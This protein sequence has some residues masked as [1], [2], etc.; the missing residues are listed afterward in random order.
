MVRT[1]LTVK[2]WPKT[3]R[4]PPWLMNRRHQPKV[5]RPFK[6]KITLPEQTILDIKKV[7]TSSRQYVSDVNQSILLTEIPEH[8]N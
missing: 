8:F 3:S 5:K 6:I 7:E 1:K 4:I 2:R